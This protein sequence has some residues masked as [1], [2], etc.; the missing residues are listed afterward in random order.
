MTT[1]T[2][3]Q[4]GLAVLEGRVIEQSQAIQDIRQELREIHQEMHRMFLG[5]MGMGATVGPTMI[6]LLVT[7]VVRQG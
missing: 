2:A 7:L 5:M 3:D 4:D 1:G 6:A